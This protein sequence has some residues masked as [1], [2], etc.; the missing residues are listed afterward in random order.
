MLSPNNALNL[1]VGANA[2]IPGSYATTTPQAVTNFNQVMMTQ[3]EFFDPFIQKALIQHPRH[4]YN[5]IPR[6]SFPNFQGVTHETRIFRGSLQHYAGLSGWD[7]IDP[8]PTN[9][10]NPCVRG[11]YE[12]VG[13]AWERMQW[14]GRSKFWGSDPICADS[15][16][17][18]P[19]AVEQLSWILQCGAEHGVS[20]QEVWN[21][22]MLIKASADAGRSFVLTSS[23]VG[24]TSPDRFY[25]DP[26]VE[27][28]SGSGQVAAATGI[29]KPF[30]VFKAGVEV[31]NINFD[32]LDSVH[33]EF[34]ASCPS[35]SVGSN[36]GSPLYGLPVAKA[37]FERY[38]KG[39]S[40]EVANWRESRS[41]QLITGISGVRTHRDWALTFDANQLRF[42]IAKVVSNYDSGDYGDVG[43]DLDGETV[44]I[45]QY[46]APRVAGRV[47]ENSQQIPEWNPE[48]FSAELAVAPLLLNKVFTNLMGSD[49]TS[50]GSGTSFGPAPGLNGQWAWVN[51]LDKTTNR[52]GKIGNFVGEFRIWPKVEPHV[53]FATSFLYRRCTEPIRSRCP[54][55]NADVNP[56]VAVGSSANGLS[57][58]ASAADNTADTFTLVAKLDKKLAEA[59]VG[60]AVTVTFSGLEAD[61]EVPGYLV[62]TSTAPTYT[63]FVTGSGVTDMVAAGN[64]GYYIVS[65]ILTNKA[66]GG[67][68]TPMVLKSVSL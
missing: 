43:A 56:D 62:Q 48:Y 34:D 18:I 5:A 32:V 40:Y 10:N 46:V 35:A 31:E 21:R 9:S 8:A 60:A 54:V 42:K 25:Y 52:H 22:D 3:A 51:I 67:T 27:F 13:Y 30:I 26:F 1:V 59:P 50:L 33:E 11:E 15:L 41:E 29:T 28:G 2:V 24:S 37:D 19:Q 45:A 17:Y 38:I 39:N 61:V 6:G 68:V 49:L 7:L 47:G 16:Q 20:L 66:G 23:F 36:G 58:V 14:T 65:G 64:A 57:H 44:I 55:D 53:V 63:I 4:W 12:T